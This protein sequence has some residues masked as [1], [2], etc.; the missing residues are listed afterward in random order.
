[1]TR[2]VS[3]IHGVFYLG[4][5]AAV[6]AATTPKANAFHRGPGAPEERIHLIAH[7]GPGGGFDIEARA[8]AR[9]MP[10]YIGERVIV[11]NVPA[12]GGRMG[13]NRM[14]LANPDGHTI[15]VL[16]LI[17]F[18]PFQFLGELPFD[19]K[20]FSWVGR[21]LASTPVFTVGA[22]SRFHNLEDLKNAKKPVWIG[23]TGRTAGGAMMSFLAAEQMGFPFQFLSGYAGSAASVTAIQ[24]GE[25][26]SPGALS[27][28]SVMPWI[29]DNLLRPIFV[30][31]KER[32]PLLPNVPTTTELGYPELSVLQT[33]RVIVAP[34]RTPP[35][36]LSVLEK[37]LAQTLKDPEF[38][39]WAEKTG[40]TPDLAPL[41]SKETKALVDELMN[42]VEKRMPILRPHMKD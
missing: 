16:N 30:F 38:S 13:A 26:E 14:F 3:V 8:I 28:T 15:G 24:R 35:E 6:I 10:K 25:L 17:G 41:G 12:A 19:L 29:N 5:M 21:Y 27:V 32:F 37:A 23:M 22:K 11:M 20:G 9:V 4:L 39:A 1:M 33:H 7:S 36:T 40:R 34:P 42:Y 31:G 2:R 18:V